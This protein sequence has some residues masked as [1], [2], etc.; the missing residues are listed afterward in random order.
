MSKKL[1]KFNINKQS[2]TV[3]ITDA[4]MRIALYVIRSLGKR[5]IKI[6]VVESKDIPLSENIGFKSKYIYK[7]YLISSKKNKEQYLN[8]IIKI[9]KNCDCLIPIHFQSIELIS[10]NIDLFKHIK[11]LI[12]NNKKLEE[13]N[14][15]Y[16]LLKLAQKISVPIPKTYF[17]DNLE[18]IEKILPELKFP[19]IIKVRKEENILPSKRHIIVYK[20]ENFIQSYKNLH[21]LQE[22]PI[23]QEYIKGKGI[24]FFG[25]YDKNSHVKAL[26]CHERLREYPITGGPSTLCKSIYDEKLI[27]YG[28]K[29]LDELRW[30]GVAM[31][32]F[33]KEYSTG[34]YKLMEIN[35]RFWGSLPL[36][37]EAGVDFPYLLYKL[38][39][40][41]NFDSIKKYK[42]GVKLRFIVIDTISALSHLKNRHFKQFF[43]FI[44]DLFNFKIKEGMLS[45]TD[46]EPT[47]PYL[48]KYFD[49]FLDSIRVWKRKN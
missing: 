42:N 4:S 34:E 26:F 2:K 36:A 24:G 43:Y 5:G 41:E 23:I 30:Q 35:P 49:Y 48:K 19:V 8:D 20:K 12:P 18:Q 33:K 10:Q 13:S 17:V 3:L 37:I 7:K 31:V 45:L 38:I 11:T 21:S 44:R 28:K 46:F 15:T 16:K 25:L 22:F 32:E 40:E 1:M 39:N 14:N 27:K 47:L 9:S 6:I 29:I